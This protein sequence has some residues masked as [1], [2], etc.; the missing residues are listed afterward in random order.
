[1][2][3]TDNYLQSLKIFPLSNIWL[4]V[5]KSFFLP[6]SD[7]TWYSDHVP[8]KCGGNVKIS[9]IFLCDGKRQ[10]PND[11]TQSFRA[12]D[13]DS[14]MC[15]ATRYL[16]PK[17][18]VLTKQSQNNLTLLMSW[19][20]EDSS[21]AKPEV[22]LTSDSDDSENVHLAGYLLSGTSDHHN[23]KKTF[24]AQVNEYR[25]SHLKPW[26]LYEIVLRPYYTFDGSVQPIYKVGKAAYTIYW[27]E[28]TA[29][30]AP[31]YAEV[32]SVEDEIITM[33]VRDPLRWNGEPGGYLVRWETLDS[34]P[35]RRG[36]AYFGI[37]ETRSLE[38]QY[39]KISMELPPGRHY[40][41]HTSVQNF[42]HQNESFTGPEVS[43]S[44]VVP[45]TDPVS[46]TAIATGPHEVTVTWRSESFV[47]Y[48]EIS[49]ISLD[50]SQTDKKEQS[51]P[52][53]DE[54]IASNKVSLSAQDV[55]INVTAKQD[56]ASAYHI[57]IHKVNPSSNVSVRVK[58]CAMGKCTPGIATPIFKQSDYLPF[59]EVLNVTMTSFE[60]R[61]TPSRY[62]HYQVRYCKKNGVCK[63]IFTPGSVSIVD[64]MPG[65][66][67]TVNVREGLRDANGQFILGPAARTRVSTRRND[68]CVYNITGPHGRISSPNYPN[69]Y[70]N[71]AS[72]SWLIKT[73][74]DFGISLEFNDFELEKDNKCITDYVSVYDGNDTSAPILGTYCGNTAPLPILSSSNQIYMVF[75]SDN[76]VQGKGFS[77]T[78]TQ[79]EKD[80]V[81]KRGSE[82]SIYSHAE[83]GNQLYENKVD[84]DWVIRAPDGHVRLRFIAFDIEAHDSCGF[85]YVKVFDGGDESAPLLNIFCGN[86]LPREITSSS[87]S[88]LLRFH[89]DQGT[90]KS[91][92][93]ALYSAVE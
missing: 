76:E 24:T 60:V 87:D 34:L 70:P 85:D 43:T 45:C 72:C 44:I 73:N 13:E 18:L 9:N 90:T 71:S 52:D 74:P 15:V 8:F 78:Y 3:I 28:A 50:T 56:A 40:G 20:F 19:S 75:V 68:S 61:V 64:L 58:S 16:P 22:E 49:A 5:C 29:P 30:T 6:F 27:S 11:T 82:Q 48:F 57:T 39:M 21:I 12:D 55:L 33:K 83:Y 88:L 84:R 46:V 1:M 32:L 26:T 47:E 14:D 86:Q 69:I 35:E 79:V 38:N 77:A 2:G 89:T 80:R 25:V 41:L 59:F 81:A 36:Q 65:T 42:G 7:A 93:V 63:T 92:F 62:S 31:A 4:K 91:G 23:F 67:Y 37:P 17:E 66:T 51:V 54:A 10:C 53:D